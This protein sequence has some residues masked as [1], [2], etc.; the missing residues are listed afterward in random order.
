MDLDE[1]IEVAL[2]DGVR[3]APRCAWRCLVATAW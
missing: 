2:K 1:K 3:L